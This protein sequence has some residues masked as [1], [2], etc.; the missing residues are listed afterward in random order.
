M[1]IAQSIK[2]RYDAASS[3]YD[4]SAP[5]SV[6]ERLYWLAYDHLTWSAV[7]RLL[8]AAG[9]PLRVLDAGGGGGKFGG[10]FAER[11]HHVTVLDLSE[12]MLDKARAALAARGLTDSADFCV[13]D[14]LS[15]PFPDRSFD[16]VFCEGDPISYCLD[17]HPRALSE[18]VRVARPGASIVIGVDSRYAHFLGALKNGAPDKALPVLRTGASLC[19]YGL[20]VHTFTVEEIRAAVAAAGAEVLEV[21]GKPVLFFQVLEAIRAER[22]PGFDLWSARD[23]IVALVER[24]AHESYASLGGHLQVMARRPREEA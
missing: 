4:A 1:T 20:P 3:G 6:E 7:E 19:P 16:L 12:G 5:S 13:G 2:A 14:V 18:L 21:F 22:G 17:E 23:E 9:E 15:L 10:M 24:L 8:P 11:G